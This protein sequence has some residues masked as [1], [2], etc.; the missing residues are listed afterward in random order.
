MIRLATYSIEIVI[1]SHPKM[2]R[3]HPV[4]LAASA[5]FAPH[6]SQSSFSHVLS[7]LTALIAGPIQSQQSEAVLAGLLLTGAYPVWTIIAVA[8]AG[9]LPGAAPLHL[10]RRDRRLDAAERGARQR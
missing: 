6:L 1:G 4:V 5:V 10:L 7:F 9:Y 8:G 2:R 3:S